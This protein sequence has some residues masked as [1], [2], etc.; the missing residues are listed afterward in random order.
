MSS[1]EQLTV[2]ER[3]RAKLGQRGAAL[4]LAI[5]IELLLIL[6]FLFALMPRPEPKVGAP[7]TLAFDVSS[8]ESDSEA[9]ASETKQAEQKPQAKSAEKPVEERPVPPDVAPPPEVPPTPPVPKADVLWLPKRDYTAT[10]VGRGQPTKSAD[11]S[12]ASGAGASAGSGRMPGDSQ[13]VGQARNGEP[14][15]GVEWYRE[16]TEAEKAP[17]LP[18][19]RAKGWA[20]IACRAAPNNRVED[21]YELAD[22]PRGSGYAGAL[23]RMA[24][25]FRIRPPRVGGKPLIGATIRVVMSVDGPNESAEGGVGPD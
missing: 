16:P 2:R 22:S 21:C 7:D 23:R 17:Y 24:W 13:I 20:V 8:G 3:M 1:G 12:A 10:D 25:Q 4:V 18:S 9:E 11:A 15:Y 5:A 14:L 19:R 6:I